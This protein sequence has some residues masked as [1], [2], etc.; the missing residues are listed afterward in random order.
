MKK[1]LL[2]KTLVISL[3]FLSC[4]NTPIKEDST[5]IDSS[6]SFPT[7]YIHKIVENKVV[8]VEIKAPLQA[9]E[10]N[11]N[12]KSDQLRNEWPQ[13]S[14]TQSHDL[15]SVFQK[16]ISESKLKNEPIKLTLAV[17]GDT[18]CRLKESKKQKSY[19]NCESSSDWP[20]P[21]IV[22]QLQKENYD[23]LIHTGDYH[24]REHCA[25]PKICKNYQGHIGYGWGAWWDDFYWPSQGL[26]NKSPVLFVR[27]NHEDCQRAYAGWGPLSSMGSSFLKICE[28]I[29][30][31]QWI[32]LNDLVLINFD[33]SAFEDRKP[34]TEVEKQLWL[35]K[36]QILVERIQNQ[37]KIN[38]EKEFWFLTHKPVYGFFP[39]SETAEP[40]E[41][42]NNLS[43]LLKQ[44]G[45]LKNIDFVL[46]GHI[47]NQQIYLGEETLKQIIVG[48][49]GS[50]LDPFGRQ[51]RLQKIISTTVNKDSFGYALFQRKAFKQWTW[52]FK[53]QKGQLV[54]SCEI[55]SKKINCKD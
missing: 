21:Q 53:D 29:E 35:K 20:Y 13:I 49:S 14:E 2:F 52:D 44:S 19:Q 24:Y 46:S 39:D 6:L 26:F 50:A 9:A 34:L 27:G 45:L 15:N 7:F 30:S 55:Q 11:K 42:S 48:H 54:L 38:K 10:K 40:T 32:E 25:D 22:K 23:F 5:Q 18:G 3:T 12:S 41:I 17:I 47:H 8:Q 33:D 28:Q 31:S 36:F 16:N 1:N 43:E 51:L 37:K 4:Q